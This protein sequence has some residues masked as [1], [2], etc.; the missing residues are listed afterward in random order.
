MNLNHSKT[1]SAWALALA[2]AACSSPQAPRIDYTKFV[3]PY[4]G[5]D[6]HGHVFIGAHVPFGA[7]QVGPTNYIRGWDW[8]SGYHYSDSVMTG[9]SQ[10][11]LSGTGIGDLGDI[12]VTPYTGNLKLSPGTINAPMSGYASRYSHAHETAE[13][14]YYAVDLLDYGIKAELTATE[15]TALH[16]YTF[17][18]HDQSRIAVNLD[19]GIGWDQP[20]KLKLAVANDTTLTGFRF[21]T[22]WAKDQR[23]FFAI[24]LSKPVKDVVL[25]RYDKPLAGNSAESD[26]LTGILTFPT[27]ADETVMLKIGVSPVSSENALANIDKELPHWDFDGTVAQAKQK[28]NR[29]LSKIDVSTGD[30]ATT[31]T[32]YTALYHAFTAPVIFNDHN[33]DYRGTDKQVYPKAPFTNYSVFSL[34]DTYRAAHP[35]FTIVQPERVSDMVNSMLAIYRQQGKLPIWALHGNETDCMVGYSAVPVVADAYFKGFSGF[36]KQLAFDAMK[37]SSTRDDYG[38]NYLKELGY[39][40]CDKEK[41]SVSKAMEYA[42]SD[43]CIAQMAHDLGQA[44]DAVYYGQ[45]AKAYTNYFDKETLFMRA[46]LSTGN[47]RTPFDPFQSTH[48]WGDYTEGNAWQYTWLVPHDVEGLVGLFGS[49]ERFATKLDSLFVVSGHMG[50]EAS[51]DISGLIGMYAQGNEPSHHVPY[52][53]AYIG[54]QWKTAGLVRQILTQMYTDKP[55]GLC[56]NEDCG[57]MSAWYVMSALGFYQVNPAN[58]VLILGSPLFDKATVKLPGQK[59]FSITALQNKPGNKYIQRATLNGTPITRSY[60]TYDELMAGG[61]LELEMGPAPNTTFGSG[62]NDRP[63]SSMHVK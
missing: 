2:L 24:R 30:L 37:A 49:E 55:D 44:G 29:E 3:D 48:E 25:Y 28:W 59:S 20:S 33:G 60:I 43:W 46:K 11:H 54:Q 32:F 31:K 7:V 56:G 38:M 14:G 52:L 26:S 15:R 36:D 39:I 45:R 22:G 17:P 9:F 5:T 42:L 63:S 13:A 6:G 41:E 40:P 47:F 23:L 62:K 35:L 50:H 34:W 10:T 51:P 53:Y 18:A 1:H 58:G 19:L 4:I 16:K 61:T 12:L 21:S 8:C 57:Q 27:Q